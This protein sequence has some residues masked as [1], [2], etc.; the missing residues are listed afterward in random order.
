MQQ[1]CRDIGFPADAPRGFL[2][3][4]AAPSC[5][6]PPALSRR[7]HSPTSLFRPLQSA[8]TTD[9]PPVTTSDLAVISGAREA[10]ALG[11][12]ALFA[13]SPGGVH[14]PRG[15]TT[16][17][18]RSVLDV[19]HVL[20]GLRHHRA[21]GFV[22]PRSHVQGSPSKELTTSRSRTGF[23]RP[24]PSC[25]WTPSPAVARS[26]SSALDFRALLPT[27]SATRPT[28]GEAHR[29]IA[30]FLGFLSSGLSLS[31]PWQRLHATSV[32]DLHRDEPTAAGPR[33]LADPELGWR[34][35][36]LPARLSFPT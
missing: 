36:T 35:I 5:H 3:C 2:R 25:R 4:P 13:T 34:G 33:R 31:E 18:L 7:V 10:P 28:N 14:L 29:D 1:D 12:L 16:S 9:L 21:C 27:T 23:H 26:G 19:S 6:R 24:L 8:A 32:R 20:D 22:S 15:G 11:F 17:A 30:P